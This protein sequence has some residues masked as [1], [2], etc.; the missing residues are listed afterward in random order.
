MRY[1]TLVAGSNLALEEGF[2]GLSSVV[3]V[4][5]PDGPL[6]FDA[7]HHTTR[8]ALL[9]ALARRGLAAGD[10]A[11]VVLSH[12]HFDHCNNVD[13]FPQA[14]VVVARRE[15]DYAAAPHPED[16]FVPWLIREQLDRQRLQLVEVDGEAEIA[17]GL[18]LLATPGHTPGHVS[19]LLE[20]EDGATVALAG[21]AIKYP[22][23]ALAGRPDMAFG[24]PEAGAA[25]IA[26]LLARAGR[27]VPGHFPELTVRE[28]AVTWAEPARLRLVA[29]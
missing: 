26:A 14:R 2:L 16:M 9:G 7:G 1:E 15:W 22:K 23:E 13:L 25:S 4:H 5:A 28:G 11:T 10:V 6:L 19:L 18:R 12:L 24:A 8:P 20:G 29:R 27:I 3:L 21:D 17:P